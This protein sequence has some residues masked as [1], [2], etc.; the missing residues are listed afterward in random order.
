MKGK[1]SGEST[2]VVGQWWIFCL[3][4]LFMNQ[5]GRSTKKGMSRM[6]ETIKNKNGN[7]Y[8]IE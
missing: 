4:L 2:T 3:M 8:E 1:I 6:F 5:D 7:T